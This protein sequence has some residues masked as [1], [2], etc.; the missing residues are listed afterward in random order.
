MLTRAEVCKRLGIGKDTFLG[1][2]R[3]G[4]LA[5]IRT[6]NRPTSPYKVSEEDLADY[7]KRSR[8]VPTQQAAAR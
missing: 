8:V 6:G 2:V 5:A 1:L 4:E 7:I 3:S